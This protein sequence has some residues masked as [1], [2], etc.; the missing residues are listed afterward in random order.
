MRKI[1]LPSFTTFSVS[2]RKY[3]TKQGMRKN[4]I[5]NIFN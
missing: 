2:K 3:W 1:L 5:K 4:K